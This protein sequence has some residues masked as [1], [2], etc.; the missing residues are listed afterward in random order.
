MTQKSV[1]P[2]NAFRFAQVTFGLVTIR[3]FRLDSCCYEAR[4][5]RYKRD[6]K[7]TETLLLLFRSISEH[8]LFIIQ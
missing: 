2:L 3:Y 6:L 1:I 8:L 5:S 4:I 7:C